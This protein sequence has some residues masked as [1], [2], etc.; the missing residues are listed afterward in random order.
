MCRRKTVSELFLPGL[1]ETGPVCE[2]VWAVRDG[3]VNLYAVQ[4]QAG[5]VCFDAGWRAARVAQGFRQLG[6]DVRDVAAVFATHLDWDHSL[7]ASLYPRAV[8]YAGAAELACRWRGRR[9]GGPRWTGVSDGETVVVG[10]LQ[11]RAICTPGHTRG[12][13]CYVADKRLLFTGDAMLLRN[14][15]AAPFYRC[16]NRHPAAVDGSIRK[17]AHLGGIG[18]VMTAHSGASSD[19]DAAFRAWRE[20]RQRDHE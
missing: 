7:G 20:G 10:G 14:G 2:R 4:A 11:V 19:P 17:L 15:A 12:S 5:L 1:L 9:R 13:M 6:L 3:C 8:L 18:Q 16:F